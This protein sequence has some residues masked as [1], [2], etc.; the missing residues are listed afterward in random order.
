MYGGTTKPESYCKITVYLQHNAPLL[1]ENIQDLCLFGLFNTRGKNGVTLLLP[2]Q[3]T[4][5][6]IDK[7]VGQDARKAVS[8]IN[9]CVLPVYLE[10]IEDF[11]SQKDDIPN[12]LGNKLPIKE[13]TSSSVELTNGAKITR[14]SKFKRLY[15][16]YNIAVYS[17]DGEVPTTGELSNNLGK[18][19]KGA[20]GGNDSQLVRGE[21]KRMSENVE[22]VDINDE[23]DAVCKIRLGRGTNHW[24]HNGISFIEFLLRHSDPNVKSLGEV[25][26]AFHPICTFYMK[27]MGPVAPQLVKEWRQSPGN[28]NYID[29]EAHQKHLNRGLKQWEVLEK[30]I[31]H[32]DEIVKLQATTV[33]TTIQ[34]RVKSVI[35]TLING[36]NWEQ[37]INNYWGSI[38]SFSFWILSLSDWTWLYCSHF[39][40][41]CK[42]HD[43]DQMNYFFD[44][45]NR[46]AIRGLIS[47]QFKTTL[48]LFDSGINEAHLISPERFCSTFSSFGSRRCIP[49]GA[50]SLSEISNKTQLGALYVGGGVKPNVIKPTTDE[51]ITANYIISTTNSSEEK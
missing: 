7:L 38:E 3:K 33:T 39:S 37:C 45:Y 4:Q 21:F 43:I 1:Y 27:W 23:L 50:S 17:L 26:C 32:P 47:K 30:G 15:D 24:L 48:L 12:K 36:R 25:F 2:D 6:K 19:K 22:W 11:R 34:E 31:K 49:M 28:M 18:S 16:T 8:M 42:N 10:S 51:H 14:D 9:A 5:A 44:A 40:T 41:A 20:R 29:L 35:P 13:V 46:W